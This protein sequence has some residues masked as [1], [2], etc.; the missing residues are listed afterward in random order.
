MVRMAVGVEPEWIL[1][2]IP[3]EISESEGLIW[4]RSTHRVDK[5]SRLGCGAVVLDE[6]R[7]PADPSP[8]A[9]RILADEALSTGYI[10][11]E[12]SKTSINII[13]AKLEVIKTAFP[14][15]SIPMI[16]DQTICDLVVKAC[17]GCISLA[18]LRATDFATR[19][20]MAMPFEVSEKLRLETPDQLTLPGGRHVPI[21]YEP[22]K[23]PWVAS[24]LQ[25]FFG[26][27]ST[28]TVCHGRVPLTVH[29]LAPNQRAVQVT[30]D[31]N[32][33]WLRHYPEIRRELCRRYPRHPWPDD[34]ATAQPPEPRNR[35]QPT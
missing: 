32:G 34:G 22:G 12:E 23:P 6:S 3:H 21:H 31:L 7:R 24:R 29:L 8:E 25:D 9:S 35:R 5:V 20:L 14:G 16:D 30:S 18:E 4:N 19:V 10:N 13:K 28:P 1:D 17:D 27:R 15:F 11:S 2:M 26:M 33:F